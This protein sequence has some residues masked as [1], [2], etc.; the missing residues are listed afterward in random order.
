MKPGRSL[1]KLVAY[2]ERHLAASDK[3]L[4]ES[5]KRLPDKTTGRLREHDV[6]LT[7]TTNHHRILVAVECRD[8]SRPVGVPQIEGFAKKC[9]ETLVDKGVI[10]S[11]CGFTA[12]ALLKSKALGIKCLCLDQVDVLPWIFNDI[13]FKQF[14]TL[15]NQFDFTVIPE[16]DF[17]KIPK[18][19]DLI[20]ERAEVIS[21]DHLRISLFN[22]IKERQKDT[23]PP[24]IGEKTERFRFIVPNL[25]IIDKDTGV[26]KKVKH[27]N[28]SVNIVT[29]VVE[30]PVSFHEYKDATLKTAISQLAV[31]KVDFGFAKGRLVIN[32]KI[33][34]GGEIVFISDEDNP[35]TSM[36]TGDE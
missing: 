30:V 32:N 17:P 2:L 27:I 7:V 29:N 3:I 9:S 11:P 23:V 5:P 25:A 13:N 33:E 34:T 28:A 4:V 20:N 26:V 16:E 14:H 22:S 36:E 10:V 15:Y 35:I 24:E 6:V 18:A 1:E 19:F 21:V 31:A 8:R 12:T